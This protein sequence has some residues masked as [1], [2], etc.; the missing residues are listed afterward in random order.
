[1]I[2]VFGDGLHEKLRALRR[3]EGNRTVEIFDVVTEGDRTP[4]W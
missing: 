3:V 4:I 2:N 1:M